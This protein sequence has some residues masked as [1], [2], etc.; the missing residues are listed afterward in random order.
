MGIFGN[1]DQNINVKT[2][3]SY[4]LLIFAMLH[5]GDNVQFK[6]ERKPYSFYFKIFV[7]SYC[8]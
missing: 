5:S 7:L 8:I 6:C 2:F 3:F 1:K 4:F